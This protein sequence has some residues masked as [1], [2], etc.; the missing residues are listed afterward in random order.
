MSSIQLEGIIAFHIWERFRGR[1]SSS[2][3]LSLNAGGIIILFANKLRLGIA[4]NSNLSSILKAM[5]L[6]KA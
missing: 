6:I 3:R 5:L 1:N 2:L 4:S